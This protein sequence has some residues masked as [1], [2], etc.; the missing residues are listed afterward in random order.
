[1]SATGGFWP[2]EAPASEEGE[3]VQEPQA[4]ASVAEPV[5]WP[6]PSE[7]EAEGDTEPESKPDYP[8]RM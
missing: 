1:M 2:G 4:E 3:N 7:Q 5:G 8:V 6:Q